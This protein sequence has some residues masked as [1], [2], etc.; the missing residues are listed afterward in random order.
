M[1][2]FLSVPQACSSATAPVPLS[3]GAAAAAAVMGPARAVRGREARSKASHAWGLKPGRTVARISPSHD[4]LSARA[5]AAASSRRHHARH[6]GPND[7]RAIH[8]LPPQARRSLRG[9]VCQ[10]Q[11]VAE[12]DHSGA[13]GERGPPPFLWPSGDGTFCFFGPFSNL[14]H[15]LLCVA[16]LQVE[17]QA[18]NTAAGV[19][20]KLSVP[21]KCGY[22]EV[23]KVRRAATELSLGGPVPRR[24]HRS[25]PR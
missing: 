14:V 25:A 10:W 9:G 7:G 21:Y 2:T 1:P 19:T 4:H 3:A 18:S 23:V 8:G 13:P 20:C 17:Q 5:R 16:L 11:R 6:K 24:D 15:L 12:R 22:G